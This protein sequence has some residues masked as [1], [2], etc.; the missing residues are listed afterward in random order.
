MWINI[1]WFWFK[2]MPC[3]RLHAKWWPLCSGLPV[4]DEKSISKH[5]QWCLLNKISD[6]EKM[7]PIKLSTVNQ[8]IR[9]LQVCAAGGS[10]GYPSIMSLVSSGQLGTAGGHAPTRF[11]CP[12]GHE[13][14]FNIKMQLFQPTI[15]NA[16]SWIVLCFDSNFTGVSL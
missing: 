5:I 6:F 12:L 4:N 9:S 14:C 8:G 16:F 2:N 10:V 3:K 11:R 1:Q 15:S 7:P 13:A